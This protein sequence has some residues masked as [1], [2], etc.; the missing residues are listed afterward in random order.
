LIETFFSRS[1]ILLSQT[2][3]DSRYLILRDYL[4]R[5]TLYLFKNSITFF[6]V[7]SFWSVYDRGIS[8]SALGMGP[9]HGANY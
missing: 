3:S 4:L 6:L 8:R 5:L 9:L 1:F 2:L 7:Y